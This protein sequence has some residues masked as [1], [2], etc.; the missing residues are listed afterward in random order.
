MAT[1]MSPTFKVKNAQL[2]GVGQLWP[3]KYH[4][5]DKRQVLM[6][7]SDGPCEMRGIEDGHHIRTSL[8]ESISDDKT[9]V[10]TMNSIYEVK[11]WIPTI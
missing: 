11:N 1:H 2:V 9:V 10:T 3:H 6:C 7:E 4:L 5:D 8:I